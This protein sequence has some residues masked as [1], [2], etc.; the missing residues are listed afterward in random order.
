MHRGREPAGGFTTDELREWAA[1]LRALSSVGKD[2]YL[3]FNNDWEGYAIRDG[4]IMQQLLGLVP[5]NP[6]LSA[7]PTGQ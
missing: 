7:R 2:V 1:Q 5:G 4:K 6:A 3:Y